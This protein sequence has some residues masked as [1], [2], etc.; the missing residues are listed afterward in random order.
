MPSCSV[1]GLTFVLAG[2][3]ANER[4]TQLLIRYGTVSSRTSKVTEHVATINVFYALID[5][6]T[7]DF[8]ASM[9]ASNGFISP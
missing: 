7:C 5:P 2:S 1:A 3:N 9:T 4:W 6:S 8:T